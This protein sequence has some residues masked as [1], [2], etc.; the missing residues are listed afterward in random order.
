ME[1]AGG[2]L[3]VNGKQNAKLGSPFF[4]VKDYRLALRTARILEHMTGDRCVLTCSNP[5]FRIIR[6]D[7]GKEV[8]QI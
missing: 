5:G 8:K 7:P 2:G 4:A 6:C 3:I 1:I